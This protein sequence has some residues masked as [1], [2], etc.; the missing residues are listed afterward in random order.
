MGVE[1]QQEAQ[2]DARVGGLQRAGTLERAGT[3]LTLMRAGTLPTED[4]EL[5]IAAVMPTTMDIE[6][7]RPFCGGMW[8]LQQLFGFTLGVGLFLGTYFA[9]PLPS[10]YSKANEMLGITMLCGI[11]WVFEVLPI[12]ITSL[13]PLILMPL[14]GITSSDIAAQAYWNPIQMLVVGTYIVDIALEQVSL[15]RRCAITILLATGVTQPGLVLFSFMF[16]SYLL[17]IFCN[18]IAV[19]LMITPFAI[20]V[21]N[22]AREKELDDVAEMLARQEESESDSDEEVV[23]TKV[24]EVELFSRGV[25]IGIAYGAT[26]GGMASLIGSIP[27]E[28]LLGMDAVP[29]IVQFGNFMQFAFPV[30]VLTFT[31][32]YASVY[33]RYIAGMRRRIITR[34]LL[35][36]EY[37][38]LISEVG[39]FG[40]DELCVGIIQIVQFLLL[41]FR[42]ALANVLVSDYGIQ[43][44]GDSTLAILPAAALFMIPSQMHPG[45]SVL[46]W[47]M[48]H[49]KFDFGLLLLI[50]GGFAIASGFMQS[51]LNIALGDGISSLLSD[52]SDWVVTFV[53]MLIC[54]TATQV[55]SAIGTATTILPALQAAALNAVRN[56][57]GLVLP[58]TMACSFSFSL[59]TAT[60]ANVVVLA[61][62]RSAS[63]LRVRDFLW[64]G[65]PIQLIMSVLGVFAVFVSG[66]VVYDAYSPFPKWACNG[67][68]CIWAHVPGMVDGV[69]VTHQA[70][71]LDIDPDMTQCKLANGSAVP[72]NLVY[73]A[74]R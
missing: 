35:E 51:G 67:V 52:T 4:A 38:D 50:G 65:L 7:D 47:P 32:A 72:F 62:S 8:K 14:F 61:K 26:T 5:R 66:N 17:S 36:A 68:S 1:G 3:N 54:A 12:Y 34:D 23:N 40:R 37:E 53:V 27:N 29:E 28:L 24:A 2:S 59:P 73:E 25:L 70:C 55:F 64:T 69:Q 10:Q 33:F 49:E 6:S 22:A 18:N 20:G 21:L 58:A 71:V 60:P 56:P 13:L 39:P 45:S 30:S 41:M 44:L 48:V 31:V 43:L 74:P 42:P 9:E 16:M 11:F 63:E 19:T 46:T 15:P 57:L